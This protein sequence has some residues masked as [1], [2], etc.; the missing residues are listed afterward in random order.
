MSADDTVRRFLGTQI[1]P[2]PHPIADMRESCATLT[3]PHGRGDQSPNG[4]PTATLRA[5]LLAESRQ[6]PLKLV[7]DRAVHHCPIPE[8]AF[9]GRKYRPEYRNNHNKG[10]QPEV[11]DSPGRI[12]HHLE[13]PGGFSGPGLTSG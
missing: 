9:G 3:P 1:S 4:S 6:S 8:L 5:S 7:M 11:E 13:D 2:G 12:R 10:E